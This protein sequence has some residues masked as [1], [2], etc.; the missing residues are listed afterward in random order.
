MTLEMALDLASSSEIPENISDFAGNGLA[1]RQG[2][3]WPISRNPNKDGLFSNKPHDINNFAFSSSFVGFRLL[4]SIF[5]L[6]QHNDTRN[7]TRRE[8]LPKSLCQR[9]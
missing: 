6:C 7:D 3:F 9:M 5:V 4:A 1:G 8:G 2:F